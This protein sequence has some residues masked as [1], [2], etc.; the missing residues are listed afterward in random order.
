MPVFDMSKLKYSL[1]GSFNAY[2]LLM[3]YQRTDPWVD[4]D[5]WVISQRP[6]KANVVYEN[7]WENFVSGCSCSPGG[8]TQKHRKSAVSV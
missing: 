3:H 7:R 4:S 6:H 2:I 1:R 8:K 5:Q